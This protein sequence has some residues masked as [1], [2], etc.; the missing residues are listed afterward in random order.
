M[1]A[2]PQ[3]MPETPMSDGTLHELEAQQDFIQRHIGPSAADQ[4]T[5]LKQLGYANLQ[6]MMEAILPPSILRQDTMPLASPQSEHSTQQRLHEIA[7]LN[8][9]KHNMIGLGY[10]DNITPPVVRRNLLENPGWYTAYTPYQAEASQGTLQ[11]IYEFQTMLAGLTGLDVSNASLYDG[12]TAFAEACLMAVR[13]NRKAKSRKIL[14]PRS[15][16][17][18]YREVARN[19]VEGQGIE[20]VESPLADGRCDLTALAALGDET[21]AAIAIQHPTFLGT[22][23]QVDTLT[24]TDREQRNRFLRAE[25]LYYLRIANAQASLAG[26][27]HV[28]VEALQLADAKL[29]ETGDPQLDAVRARLAEDLTAL[30]AV[31]QLDITGVAFRLQSLAGQV[32]DWP[33]RNPAPESFNTAKP[34]VA[35]S[36]ES[37]ATDAW[38]RFK[39]TVTGVFRTIVKVRENA[40]RPE[41]QLS[42]TQHALVI[43]SVRAELQLAR[44]AYVTGEFALFE[45]ALNN[46]DAQIRGYFATDSGAVTAA[47]EALA[48]L[49]VL[50]RPAAMPDVSGAAS[51]LLGLSD[52]SESQ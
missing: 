44:L 51:L 48:E 27:A 3:A 47:L 12:A 42:G 33:L 21:Y 17:P 45:Q 19:M 49:T 18:V 11:V 8:Q 13:A 30:R 26:D 41:V 14:V 50:E 34:E 2:T 1:S 4:Q 32:V 36:D 9:I 31:P 10:H 38:A 29:R 25:A 6:Q 28:A 43:E 22:L 23:E 24:G 7:S 20:L 35:A 40:D 5:M 37:G 46:A 16:S 39:A 15:L 52:A